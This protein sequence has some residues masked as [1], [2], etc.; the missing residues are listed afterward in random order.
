[1]KSSRPTHNMKNWSATLKK[2]ELPVSI[3]PFEIN[4]LFLYSMRTEKARGFLTFS[5]VMEMEHW[6]EIG[7]GN[8]E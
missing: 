3:N 8:T 7:W 2:N 4:V 1:M 6:L 5:G